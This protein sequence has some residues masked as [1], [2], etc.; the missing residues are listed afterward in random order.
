M[1]HVPRELLKCLGG[2]SSCDFNPIGKRPLLL[3][4]V[5]L[6]N[7]MAGTREVSLKHFSAADLGESANYKSWYII[8]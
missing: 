1:I 7:R 8:I 2:S 6:Y 3:S 5:S 4:K